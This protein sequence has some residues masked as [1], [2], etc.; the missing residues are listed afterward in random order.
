[1][2]NR[3]LP[4]NFKMKI[5]I[6]A[7]KDGYL[8][9]T[10]PNDVCKATFKV[11]VSDWKDKVR[12]EE[13]FC[14]VCGHAA[15]SNQWFSEEQI[16][17]AKSRLLMDF[18][19]MLDADMKR[20]TND[21]NSRVPKN[22]LIKLSM[23]YK[24]SRPV[25]VVPLIAA[26]LMNQRYTCELCGCRYAA[27]G[28]AFFCPSCGH[29]SAHTALKE[30]LLTIRKLPEVRVALESGLNRD[31]AENTLRLLLEE[32]MGKLVSS[33]QRFAEVTFELLPNP[34][35]VSPRRNLFQNLSQSSDLWEQTIG[36]RYEAMLTTVEW[37]QLQRYFQQRH[38]LAHKDGIVD[39]DYLK[40]T[41]DG[42][43]RSGQRLVVRESE[44]MHFTDLVEK[45]ITALQGICV[46]MM[47]KRKETPR[48]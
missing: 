41:G 46:D 8:D 42:Q 39:E 44:V 37:E 28:A 45:L 33:F 22:G 17:H 30:T 26:E 32:N 29:N 21:F 3:N 16:E 43:Y 10:C 40:K 20:M 6:P 31:A 25:A 2:S 18:M 34:N 23:S 14:P 1:M 24:L 48:G 9:R 7:D 11:L 36:V 12:D 15:E 38:V 19:P 13:V 47:E 35:A 5:D 4:K 27:I